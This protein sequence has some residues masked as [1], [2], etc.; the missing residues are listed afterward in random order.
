LTDQSNSL[1]LNF[2]YLVHAT[3]SAGTQA[4]LVAGFEGARSQ[5]SVLGIG[6]RAPKEADE[7]T[8][9]NLAVKTAEL[10]GCR[11]VLR[12]KASGRIATVLSQ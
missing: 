7:T 8:A 6:G 12:G 9:F 2:D 3:G 10:L 11:V 1:G 5:I 4:G